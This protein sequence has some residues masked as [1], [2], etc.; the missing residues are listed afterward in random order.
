[1]V[2]AD[3]RAYRN[4]DPITLAPGAHP[5][6]T[7][8]GAAGGGVAGAA[9]G[10]V[11]GPLGAAVGLVAG[12]VVGGLAGKATAERIN[13]TIEEAYWRESYTREPYYEAGRGYDDY[14]PA[15]AYGWYASVAYPGAFDEI[16][17]ALASEW[18]RQR[19][20]SSLA[21]AQA[22]P[23]TRAA[24]SRVQAREPA[25]ESADRDAVLEVLDDL[26]KSSRD[27]QKGFAEAAGH[28]RTAALAQVLRERAD[29]CAQG[30][31]ELAAAVTRLGGAVHDHGSASGALHRGWLGLR[32]SVGALTDLD[33]L[34]EGERAED[35]ALAR[36]RRALEQPLP[37]DLRALVERL[38]Q[39]TR[40]S[41]DEI[42]RLRDAERAKQ[43]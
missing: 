1:M 14:G 31:E 21:W 27:G 39:G 24:W 40:R 16:E 23:A 10:A 33:L 37:A 15:Y 5:V 18:E 6:G 41:H 35:A 8:V 36:C 12:A 13:P 2:D 7:G 43:G 4:L 17:P 34:E 28:T 26:L 20:T 22:R 42:R 11:G 19:G 30:A 25:D 9:I 38:L 29:A 32:G 3:E